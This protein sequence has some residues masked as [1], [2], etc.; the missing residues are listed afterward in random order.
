MQAVITKTFGTKSR[1]E[2]W[3]IDMVDLERIP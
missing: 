3:T 2:P 1:G